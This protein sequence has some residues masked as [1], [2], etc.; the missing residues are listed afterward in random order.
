MK[1]L[2]KH[3]AVIVCLL[4]LLFLNIKSTHD[5][6]DDFA[7]YLLEAKNISNGDPINTSGFVENPNYILGPNCYPPGL[8]LLIA[9]TSENITWLN[10]LM[11]FF[12]V[13][14]GYFSFL[15]LNK[16]FHFT[17]A[18]ILSLVV[19]YNPLCLNFKN[20]VLS[21][22]PFAA[23]S[24]LFFVLYLSDNKKKWVLVLCGFILAFAVNTRYVGWVLFFALLA[25]IGFKLA[26]KYFKNHKKDKEYLIQQ[27]W[28]IISF[29]VFHALFYLI[30]PQKIIYYDNPKV[31]S[32]FERISV[33]ANYNYAVLKYFFSCFDEGFLN[34]VVSYGIVFTSLVG[35]ILFVFKPDS[36]KPEILLFFLLGYVLSILI[37][38]YSDTGFRLLIP[39]I[40]LIL[41]FATYALF[42]VLVIIPY[43]QYIVFSLG[44]LVLFC[45]K[46][47]AAKI[48]L[49]KNEIPGPYSVQAKETFNFIEKNTQ[50]ED[51]ILFAKPRA[52]TYFTGRKTF[53]NT[54]LAPKQEI[55]REINT[56]NPKYIL[57]CNEITDD[58]TKSYF[59]ELK[60]GFEISFENE[61]FKLLKRK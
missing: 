42:I 34:Y 11:S 26:V 3:T 4:P 24:L 19:V 33:N 50:K 55:E 40:P 56:V 27:A 51:G 13:C 59:S 38:Q 44:L 14:I 39:I 21:D 43:K 9:L 5:W 54:E 32:F 18:L 29:F 20:E 47:N 25:E 22:L 60:P 30:F 52:L 36:R 1:L 58:S 17:P 8:P 6:G 12:L 7:Q 49:S 10:V 46:Q 48:L 61:K 28:I 45:Y 16:W 57:I 53:V 31:L 35:I 23:L 15:L 41:F 37:H 2:L